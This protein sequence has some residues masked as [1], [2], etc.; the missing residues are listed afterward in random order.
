[1]PPIIG[2]C[3]KAQ[4][5]DESGK[6]VVFLPEMTFQAGAGEATR[7]PSVRSFSPFRL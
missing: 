5:V 2:L 7:G 6:K 4:L 1:M 3:A